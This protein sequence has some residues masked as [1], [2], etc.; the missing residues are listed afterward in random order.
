MRKFIFVAIVFYGLSFDILYAQSTR[1]AWYIAETV[2]SILTYGRYKRAF[3][4]IQGFEMDEK[5]RL[6]TLVT[7]GELSIIHNNI[8]SLNKKDRSDWHEM[9]NF[10]Y[11]INLS[12]WSKNNQD[13]YLTSK[14]FYQLEGDDIHVRVITSKGVEEYR[15]TSLIGG[16]SKFSS[17]LEMKGYLFDF[18][19]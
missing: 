19:K 18:I 15:Y 10:R 6:W 2:D 8:R 17:I 3:Y 13:H 16:I 14:V 7:S 5:G 4:P 1:T 9:E 11:L 12:A